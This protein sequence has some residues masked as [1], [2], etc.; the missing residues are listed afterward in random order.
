MVVLCATNANEM[1]D[2]VMAGITGRANLSSQLSGNTTKFKD[3]QDG[4][5]NASITV[6]RSDYGDLK[7][8]PDAK[9]AVL[10][11]G[12][13]PT[14]GQ[15]AALLMGES[16]TP[17]T[18]RKGAIWWLSTRERESAQQLVLRAVIGPEMT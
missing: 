7:L 18:I 12:H 16:P 8:V 5:L 17:W 11:V 3:M 10:V 2:T 15:A 13:Q 6:Y 1:P 14:L 9:G 4:K